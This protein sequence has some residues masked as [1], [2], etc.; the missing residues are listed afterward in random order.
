MFQFRAYRFK[1]YSIRLIFFIT[2]LSLLGVQVI[3][4]ATDDG[5]DRKQLVCFAVGLV[6][7]LFLSI[8]DYHFILKFH[9]LIYLVNLGLLIYVKVA[10]DSGGGAQRWIRFGSSGLGIQP[11]ELAKICIILF[12]AW[13]LHKYQEQMNS[14][15]ILAL[16]GALFLLPFVLIYKQP[17]LSSSI[18]LLVIFCSIL[19]L[20]GLSYW[21]I[22]GVL[23]V[24]IPAFSFLMYKI[25]QPGQT[26]IN[27][28]QKS[29][30]LGFLYQD[31][32]AEELARLG[33][34]ISQINAINYQQKNSVL[35]IGSGQLWG[36][37]LEN[38]TV[39]S[40]K[41]GNFLSEPQTDFIYAIVGEELGFVGALAVI[42][43]LLFIALECLWIARNAKDLSGRLIAGG[44]AA[45]IAFQSFFNMGVATWILPNTG[46]PL[47]FVSYGMSSLMSLLLGMGVV[48]NVSVQRE[49]TFKEALYTEYE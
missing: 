29:R 17:D 37:G 9:W 6:I 14:P 20:A 46:L 10:G 40:V 47:P 34:D 22:G 39:A 31:S 35:A 8:V 5:S 32:S 15:K 3:G 1:Y 25:L 27:N 49:L 24:G 2:C 13:M 48:L 45:V 7:M 28:Y 19:F 30:F 21:Y 18:V 33:L 36:K 26:L 44:M 23:A 16:A 38:N 4:S 12:F 43:L 11:S 41:N 42:L